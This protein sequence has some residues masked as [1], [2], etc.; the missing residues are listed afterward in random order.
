M[1]AE[2]SRALTTATRKDACAV[3]S[4]EMDV[5]DSTRVTAGASQKRDE[6]LWEECGGGNQGFP[7]R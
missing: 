7:G 3:I 1:V 4:Q 5:L 2:T 6:V